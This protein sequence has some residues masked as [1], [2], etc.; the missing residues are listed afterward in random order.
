MAL[1]PQDIRRKSIFLSKVLRHRPERIGLRLDR[2][3]WAEVEELVLKA[4]KAGVALSRQE[5]EEVVARTD[6]PRFS[7][8]GCGTR[9]K[10]N[11][12]HSIEVVPE[13]GPASPPRMLYHG[14]AGRFLDSI[15]EQ[16]LRPG[17][18]RFVHL[19]EDTGTAQQVGRR[20]GHPV[21]LTIW[22]AAM[23]RD[24]FH[25]YAAAEGFWL[26]AFVPPRYIVFP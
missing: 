16:G 8:S 23:E 17:G 20:R 14:T 6:K 5:L 18:R 13:A 22:A 19:V 1:T 7:L 10:A 12:G 4:R 11:Y 26:T 3:G 15:G 21:L 9:V 25:F 2:H 24:G